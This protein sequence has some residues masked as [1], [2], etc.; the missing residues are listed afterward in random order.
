M[1][2]RGVCL[3]FSAWR[4]LVVRNFPFYSEWRKLY[5]K[6]PYQNVT[7]YFQILRP[8]SD[9]LSQILQK[10]ILENIKR[11]Y[12]ILSNE[13]KKENIRCQIKCFY[14]KHFSLIFSLLYHLKISSS[15]D[16]NRRERDFSI[17]PIS[18]VFYKSLEKQ[19]C[20]L[21]LI[22]IFSLFQTAPSFPHKKTQIGLKSIFQFFLL[23]MDVKGVKGDTLTFFFL[24]KELFDCKIWAEDVALFLPTECFASDGLNSSLLSCICQKNFT[25]NPTWS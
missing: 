22:F 18:R 9:K 23:K 8:R 1:E 5:L 10:G 4:F 14:V 19:K 15:L 7:N 3:K 2:A 21:K 11:S 24:T 6:K 13:K 25:Q 20:F 16:S 12:K 17:S